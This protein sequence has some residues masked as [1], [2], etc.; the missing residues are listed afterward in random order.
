MIGR[1]ARL[2]GQD[3]RNALALKTASPD[4]AAA[5]HALQICDAEGFREVAPLVFS[6]LSRPAL[7]DEAA[8]S[9]GQFSIKDSAST[10]MV[11]A[12]Q[13]DRGLQLDAM[14]S[15]AVLADPVSLPTAQALI[16]S[17]DLQVRGAAIRLIAQLPKGLDIASAMIKDPDERAARTGV[18]ILGRIGTPEA[19]DL[20]GRCL[21]DM[22]SGVRIQAL[23]ALNGRTPE[24]YQAALQELRQDPSPLVRAV[25]NGLG[26]GT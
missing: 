7:Q 13:N 21:T 22:K 1:L 14:N 4:D 18:Q 25:F 15:L 12:G 10:L 23:L 17:D 16:G 8:R 20:I 3:A 26:K 6:L 11:L 5:L 19:L 2:L 24:K 9:C